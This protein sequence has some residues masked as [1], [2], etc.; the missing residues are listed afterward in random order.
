MTNQVTLTNSNI[1]SGSPMK[2][3]AAQI[4]Y[5]WVNLVSVYPRPGAFDITPTTMQGWQNPGINIT[6]ILEQNNPTT[7]TINMSQLM[8]VVKNSTS[9]LTY[10]SITTGI[11]DVLFGSYATS[12]TAVTSIPIQIKD[13]G[14]NIDPSDNINS[15]KLMVTMNCVETK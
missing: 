11:S 6:F 8:Q 3:L 7:G 1:N 14:F 5:K 2:L 12:S 10:L 4:S 13:I 9:A 15:D